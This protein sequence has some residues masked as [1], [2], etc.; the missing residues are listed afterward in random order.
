MYC[1]KYLAFCFKLQCNF[2]YLMIFFICAMEFLSG[3]LIYIYKHMH[4]C[5]ILKVAIK[6]VSSL[7]NLI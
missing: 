2:A 6:D 1:V 4:L 5:V 7:N 3:L